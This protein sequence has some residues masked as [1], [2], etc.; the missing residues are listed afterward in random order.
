MNPSIKS[1]IQ[2]APLACSLGAELRNV[3]LRAASLD[4]EL[5]SD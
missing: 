3:Q 1:F 2:V 5:V 4:T